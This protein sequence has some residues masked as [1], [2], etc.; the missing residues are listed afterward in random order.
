MT[1]KQ[2]IEELHANGEIWA[3]E[4][5][6]KKYLEDYLTRYQNAM[7]LSMEELEARIQARVH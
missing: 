1:K 4:S 5:Y 2:I 3:N 7:T 6:S